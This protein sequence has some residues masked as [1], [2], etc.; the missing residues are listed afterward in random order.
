MS[1]S[2]KEAICGLLG[3]GAFLGVEALVGLG[4]RRQSA[5]AMTATQ[6]LVVLEANLTDQIFIRA[7]SAWPT[8]CSYWPT[9]MSD[10]R[11]EVHCLT[12]RKRSSP[13]WSGPR[14]HV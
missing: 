3:T 7:S 10:V 12:S 5:I 11:T 1:R 6:V 2:G 4:E 13:K 8:R 14:A 9:A